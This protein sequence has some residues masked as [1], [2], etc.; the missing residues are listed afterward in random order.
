[1]RARLAGAPPWYDAAMG[2]AR[3]I[4]EA[5]VVVALSAGAAAIANAVREDPLPW[6]ATQEYAVHVPCPEPAGEVTAI[7]AGD[8]LIRDGRTLVIDA[9]DE[10][11]FREWHLPGARRVEFDW[12]SPV[13]GAA[14]ADVAASGAAAVVVYGDG[15]DPDSGRELARELSGRGIRNVHHVDGGAPALRGPGPGG[16]P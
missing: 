10:T 12:V 9:R 4:V 13:P 16:A 5:A 15:G 2:V 1:M 7:R 11:A 3:T 8:P 14:L 6:V